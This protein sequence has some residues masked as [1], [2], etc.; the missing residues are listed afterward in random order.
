MAVLTKRKAPFFVRFGV[1]MS[2][3]S[4]SQMQQ[5]HRDDYTGASAMMRERT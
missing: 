1:A 4:E 3:R 2:L 5:V